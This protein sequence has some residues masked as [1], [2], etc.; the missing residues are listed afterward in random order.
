MLRRILTGPCLALAAFGWVAAQD[1]P[2]PESHFGY[3]I[4]SEQRLAN[5]TE[6]TSYYERLAQT[7]ERVKVD[8]LGLTTM[9]QP[10][11]MV[12]VTSEENQARLAELQDI[13]MRL[14]DPRR[15]ADDDEL[16]QLI[17]AG[18]TVVLI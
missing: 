14:A 10:F 11:V 12:T 4:G 18:R 2:T 15:V 6:L 1:V 8:T 7:S 5:W 9:G 3:E 17:A 13:Q 16:Q